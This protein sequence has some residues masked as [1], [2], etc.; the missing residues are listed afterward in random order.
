M[1]LKIE[2]IRISDRKVFYPTKIEMNGFGHCNGKVQFIEAR[3]SD[4][5]GGEYEFIRFNLTM[6][7]QERKFNEQYKVVQAFW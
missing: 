1:E 6:P 5:V 2:I 4:S 7:K 3:E